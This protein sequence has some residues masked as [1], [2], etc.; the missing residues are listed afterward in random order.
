MHHV[1]AMQLLAH[2]VPPPGIFKVFGFKMP[3]LLGEILH[4][5]ARLFRILVAIAVAVVLKVKGKVEYWK[6]LIIGLIAMV[7]V[8]SF[9]P[10]IS[11]WTNDVTHGAAVGSTGASAG[12]IFFLAAIGIVVGYR[13]F[14]VKPVM[15]EEEV[16][17]K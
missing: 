16:E 9:S 1:L 2:P 5:A 8:P 4:W 6:M 15:V 7:D 11:Q 12:M 10:K 14:F 3:T 17:Q 13:M